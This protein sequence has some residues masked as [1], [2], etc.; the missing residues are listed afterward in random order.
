MLLPLFLPI[1]LKFHLVE[2]DAFLKIPFVVNSNFV[3]LT[4]GIST[5]RASTAG[6]FNIFLQD[7]YVINVIKIT[8]N[9][10]RTYTTGKI[11]VL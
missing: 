7:K 8:T 1:S 2:I 9:T 6:S 11:L 5:L 3:F 10:E 4:F